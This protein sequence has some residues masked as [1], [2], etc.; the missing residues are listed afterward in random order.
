MKILNAIQGS[1]EWLQSR[2]GVATASNF[3]K[4]VTS[5]GDLAKPY[6]EYALELASQTLLEEPEES[7]KSYDMERGNE[8]EPLAREAYEQYNFCTV[9]EV[10]LMIS[11]CGNWG[12]SSDGLVSDDGSIEIKCPKANNHTKYITDNKCP[13]KYIAQIQG[14]LMLSG[15]KWCDFVSYHPD[16]KEGQQLFIFRVLRDQDFI[17]K[18]EINISITIA[19]RDEILS[20]IN[21]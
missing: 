9:K 15:R 6:T 5:K 8:L 1:D 14:G 13:T 3:S 7:F 16:F 20:N 4:I 11:D 10:G 12:A 19:K 21:N 2:L 17:D 18:L